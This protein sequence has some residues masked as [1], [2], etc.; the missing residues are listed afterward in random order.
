M[1]RQIIAGVVIGLVAFAAGLASAWL[2]GQRIADR[3]LDDLVTNLTFEPEGRVRISIW[4]L[5]LLQRGD[6]DK[7]IEVNCRTARSAIPL[8]SYADR[9]PARKASMDLLA[10]RAE[11]VLAS[12]ESAGKCGD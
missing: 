10:T 6:T 7:A 12:L 8:L 5:E 4:T 3:A 2:V 9:V 1:S 11:Q